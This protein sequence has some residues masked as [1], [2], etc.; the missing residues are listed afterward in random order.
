MNTTQGKVQ[1]MNQRVCLSLFNQIQ[2]TN[3]EI[4]HKQ[5]AETPN[6]Y[7]NWVTTAKMPE[8]C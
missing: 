3:L 8:H 6:A 1:N 5:L 4:S 7:L 2:I